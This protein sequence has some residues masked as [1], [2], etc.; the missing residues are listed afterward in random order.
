MTSRYSYKGKATGNFKVYDWGVLPP[1]LSYFMVTFFIVTLVPSLSQIFLINGGVM[2]AVNIAYII[3]LSLACFTLVLTA[4]TEPGII[5]R[6]VDPQLE[7]MPQVY[8]DMIHK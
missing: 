7:Y 5:P 1:N 6:K 8:I 2:D 3:T 4:I